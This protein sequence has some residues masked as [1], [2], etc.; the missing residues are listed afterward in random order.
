MRNTL[1]TSLILCVLATATFAADT[2]NPAPAIVPAPVALTMQEGACTLA[3]D[4]RVVI[5]VYKPKVRAVA[6][7]LVSAMSDQAGW[8]LTVF[9]PDDVGGRQPSAADIHLNLIPADLTLGAEGYELNVTADE[10]V[11]RAPTPCGL[12]RATQTL[13]QLLHTAIKDPG[14]NSRQIPCMTI[15]DYPRYKWRGMLLDCGRHF[16]DKE[17]VKRYI[18][19][20]AYHKMN[21]L[22]W[23]LT[24]DQGWRI[25]IKKYPKLT[26]ISAWRGEGAQ[27]YGGFYSQEDIKEIVAY[28]QSRYVTIVPEIEMPGHSVA[29]L[30][31]YP[32]LSCTGGPFDV[33][34]RWGVHK[35]VYCAGDEQTFEF[36]ENVLSE[37]VELF[38]SEFIHIGGDE[39]PKQRWEACPKC[40]ARI[41]AEGLKD[42]HELQSYFIRRIEKFLNSKGKRLV[43]WDEIL[44]GGLAPNATVQSWRGMDGAVAAAASGHD[45]IT[46]PTSHCY[47][48]Y[49]QVRLPGEPTWM[50][51]V[52]LETCYSFEPTPLQLMPAQAAHV[53]GVEGN[54]WTEHAPQERVDWQAFPRLCALS[55]VG[56]SPADRRDWDDFSARLRTHYRRLD[57]L[58]VTY[59]IP[60]P[61]C[62]SRETVFTDSTEVILENPLGRGTV[63]YT[64]DGTD[65]TQNSPEYTNPIK[66]SATT[67]VKARTFLDNQRGSSIAEYN[68]VRQT[69]L[70]PIAV[71]DVQS[72]LTYE[73]Y[74]GS[75]RKLPDFRA[76]T[77]SA[78]GVAT[79]IDL[80]VSQRNDNFALRFLGYLEVP[81]DGLYTFTLNSDDGSKLWIG[82]QVVVD[83]DGLHGATEKSGQIIL[84]AGKHPICVIF[85]QAGGGRRLE[86]SYEGP[87]V[88]KQV[89]PASALWRR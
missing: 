26:E 62:V 41:K 36:L 44:E 37:V 35:E 7:Y 9:G 22:H 84:R 25:E 24:E 21:V 38:P 6:D 58:G 60:P 50:G 2:D 51:Y 55:E 83:H 68:F 71:G 75:F 53:L 3:P 88:T 43:G 77:Q 45:V 29:A 85:F 1:L 10:V 5:I 30:A 34:T 89:I 47:L 63:R 32:E 18:D 86:V 16:M 79:T 33:S 73:Y 15:R 66:L 56:W 64:L 48:D 59:F 17:F 39:C 87:S 12:F 40:Q 82:P 76:L 72:G 70:V 4:A 23:H 74:E 78:A 11:L 31:A 65:P 57:A 54:M 13:R 28:A 49:A 52:D 42:E 14:T 69:P 27:R 61:K 19:L 80:S 46:S 8:N 81:A 67:T 20:L